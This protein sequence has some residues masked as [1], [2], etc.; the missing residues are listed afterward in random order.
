MFEVVRQEELE[1]WNLEKE[2]IIIPTRKTKYS[3]GYDFHI[4]LSFDKIGGNYLGKGSSMLVPTGIKCKFPLSKY[5]LFLQISLKS[6]FAS[7]NTIMLKNHVGII[8]ADYYSNPDNDGHI[9]IS[10]YN[11]GDV[12]CILEPGKGIAQGIFVEY[13]TFNEEVSNSRNGGFG[14]TDTSLFR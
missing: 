7:K 3:A 12:T 6:G 14:S 9:L 1:N 10:L 11:Y 8:D 4:P 13:Y 5:P 2:H